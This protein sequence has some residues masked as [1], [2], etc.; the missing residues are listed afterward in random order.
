M[1]AN[2]DLSIEGRDGISYK[3]LK[4]C[5]NQ[6]ASVYTKPHWFIDEGDHQDFIEDTVQSAHE[7]IGLGWRFSTMIRANLLGILNIYDHTGK[8]WVSMKNKQLTQASLQVVLSSE[9]SDYHRRV[10][11]EHANTRDLWNQIFRQFSEVQTFLW[12]RD[13]VMDSQKVT[14]GHFFNSVRA[15]NWSPWEEENLDQADKMVNSIGGR[16]R[17][18]ISGAV[19]DAV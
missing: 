3:L 16:L 11:I 1:R 19:V 6:W 10:N 14:P 5:A 15:A 7:L 4:V 13:I 8:V 9:I 2:P 12:C 17:R 18:A